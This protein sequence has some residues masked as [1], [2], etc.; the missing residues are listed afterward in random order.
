MSETEWSAFLAN[1]KAEAEQAAQAARQDQM[2]KEAG[3]GDVLKL[4]AYLEEY[5]HALKPLPAMETDWVQVYG[6]TWLRGNADPIND[7][8]AELKKEIA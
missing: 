5:L 6:D 7:A 4:I 1:A 2:Q 8:I 3:R